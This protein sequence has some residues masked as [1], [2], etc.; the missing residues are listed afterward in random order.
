LKKGLD[1]QG[2]MHLALEIDQTGGPVANPQDALDRAETVIR[3]RIDEFGVEEPLIQQVGDERLIVELPGITNPDRAKEIVE[4]A[5]FLEFRI[6]DME[7]RFDAARPSIDAA[8]V[9]AGIRP[10]AGGQ[11]TTQRGL[12]E[13]IGT[14]TTRSDSS[15]SD[16]LQADT[17]SANSLLDPTQ[18]GIFSRLLFQ[19]SQ[20]GEFLVPQE[21]QEYVD[22]L[23][24]LQVFQRAVP[25]GI[26]LMWSKDT[27]SQGGRPFRTLYALEDQPIITGEYLSDAQAQIDPTFNQAVVNFQLTRS[28]GRIF[29]RA[30]A[31]HVGDFMAIVLD[32]RVQ[33]RPPVIRSQITRSGQIELGSASIQEAQDLALVLRAGALPAPLQIVEER[34]VGPSLGVDSIRKGQVAGIVAMVLV[35]L[36]MLV[37]YRVA[38][39]FAVVALGF[40]VLFALGGLAMLEATLTLPGLAGFVLSLGLAVD[41]NVLIFERIREE[42]ALNKS[43]RIAVDSGFKAAMPAI[44][45]ANV[46]T[47]ITAAF[48]F[49]FGTGPV[50]GFAVTLII[51][52]AASLI[53]AVF[54]TRTLFLIWLDRRPAT[55]EL[56]I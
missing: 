54:V 20:P 40:Y 55:A 12:Q 29:G 15:M 45:D 50:R 14:D 43:A 6:V 31:Q 27:L 13:L 24:Q 39:V 38:G 21:D 52:I 53:T 3:S 37:Y 1:L 23:I 22:S 30:T 51:G 9:R 25:R 35:V 47:V 32:R 18:P 19:G 48:L 4:R 16:S 5:A 49:Q 41:A 44:I 46:T 56:S 8:L 26:E 34:T 17:A 2:G 36:L 11:G 42:L 10:R 33:G 7:N 28:G